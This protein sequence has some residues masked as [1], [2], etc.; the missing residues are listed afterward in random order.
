MTHS[1]ISTETGDLL[2]TYP[3]R[4]DAFR[5][6]TAAIDEDPATLDGVAI[7]VFDEAGR[8]VR[9][10]QGDALRHAVRLSNGDHATR[11]RV[12][13]YA[14]GTVV[15]HATNNVLVDGEDA[16]P[17]RVTHGRH[18]SCTPC[19]AQNWNDPGL[20]PCGMHPHGC[21][22]NADATRNRAAILAAMQASSWW[23]GTDDT[24]A[25]YACSA[26]LDALLEA[27]FTVEAK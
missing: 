14:D 2:A 3:S 18:C 7:A 23:N 5:A 20:A 12:V 22:P 15:D 9:S 1:I 6:L 16:I 13:K 19:R 17:N 24:L 21:P 10:I 8:P 4:E 11:N 25:F 27:G 26:M